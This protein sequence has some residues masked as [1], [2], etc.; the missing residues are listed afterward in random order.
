MNSHLYS[1]CSSQHHFHG[2]CTAVHTAHTDDRNGNGV[3]NLPYHPNSNREDSWARHSAD[4]VPQNRTL[5]TNVNPH[6]QQ[7][8]DEGN[9]ICS[10]SFHC[11][12]N[13]G[14]IGYIWR[15][16]DHQRLF[17]CLPNS[18]SNAF[19][20]VAVYAERST[21]LFHVR[22][23]DV[24]F[25]HVDIGLVEPFCNRDTF[26]N[27]RAGNV[28]KNYRVL[29]QQVRQFPVNKGINARI[30][31]ADR[32]QH[33]RRCFCNS[34]GGVARTGRNGRS[35]GG[36]TAQLGK[37]EQFFIFVSVSEYTGSRNNWIFKRNTRYL[38]R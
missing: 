2:S 4:I 23:G 28:G 15:E 8:I 25:N 33:A 38:N 26:F 31:Q 32:V 35:L 18:R 36:D 13:F 20:R 6:A 7:G 34:R 16:L 10:G 12:C 1:T 14:D 29:G 3:G 24:Q 9:G 21:A 11:L 19:R 22:A 30:L 27:G 5:G 37:R 17:G